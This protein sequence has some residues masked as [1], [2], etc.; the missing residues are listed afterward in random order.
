M[1]TEESKKV[2]ADVTVWGVHLKDAA[3]LTKKEREE[4]LFKLNRIFTFVGTEIPEEIELDGE[5]VALHDVMWRLI[6]HKK[7]LTAEEFAAVQGLDA[8][9]ERKIKQIESTIR[10]Q[11]IDEREALALYAEAQGLIRAAVEL[12]DLEK[13]K[14]LKSA[15]PESVDRN[16]AQKRWLSYLKKIS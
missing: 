7:E 10:S 2:N 4:L 1:N 15:Q 6:N 5:I 14:L 9:I 8:A 12:R 11:N 3:T 13:G 16:E